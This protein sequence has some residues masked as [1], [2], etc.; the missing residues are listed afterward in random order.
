MQRIRQMRLEKYAAAGQQQSPLNFS[1]T[2]EYSDGVEYSVQPLG[3]SWNRPSS[4]VGSTAM[5]SAGILILAIWSVSQ[6]SIRDLLR[7]PQNTVASHSSLV[8]NRPEIN[9]TVRTGALGIY[10]WK[11]DCPLANGPS[12]RSATDHYVPRSLK[13]VHLLKRRDAEFQGQRHCSYCAEIDFWRASYRGQHS[14][15]KRYASGR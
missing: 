9:A 1:S 6:I 4:G 13:K 5:I 10:H 7:M 11:P 3:A 12:L 2:Q 14:E 15:R 8:E